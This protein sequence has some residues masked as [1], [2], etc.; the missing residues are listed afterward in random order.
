MSFEKA[1]ARRMSIAEKF[2]VWFVKNP[3]LL[4]TPGKVGSSTIVNSLRAAGVDEVQPHSLRFSIPGIYFVCAPRSRAQT[5]F[6]FFCTLLLRLKIFLYL[7]SKVGRRI[8]IITLVRSPVDRNISAFFEHF[9]HLKCGDVTDYSA[10]QLEQMFYRFGDHG[11]QERWLNE[12]IVRVFGL[13]INDFQSIREGEPVVLSKGNIDVYFVRT[14]DLDR[15][16]ESLR[17]WL[18]LPN[19]MLLPTNRSANKPYAEQYKATK[20]LVLA[21][22]NYVSSVEGSDFFKKFYATGR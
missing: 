7:V 20:A 10:S 13:H 9:H 8:K 14:E 6:D 17:G 1:T 16:F 15:C 21:N 3:V 5:C 22:E 18:E 2:R 4:Y 19:L 12:E 11:A